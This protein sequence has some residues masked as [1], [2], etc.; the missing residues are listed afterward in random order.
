MVSRG[1]SVLMSLAVLISAGLLT[2]GGLT[3]LSPTVSIVGAVL[4]LVL[5]LL[6]FLG[7]VLSKPPAPAPS[8]GRRAPPGRPIPFRENKDN[9]EKVFTADA[10]GVTITV[11]Y[12]GKAITIEQLPLGNLAD[13][14]SGQE[15]VSEDPACPA[16]FKPHRLAIDFQAVD[17]NRNLLTRFCVPLTMR[18]YISQADVAAAGGNPD[19]LRLANVD[20]PTGWWE[21]YDARPVLDSS[22][23]RW[24]G[25]IEA[26]LTKWDD[27]PS[28]V[29]AT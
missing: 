8:G 28:G 2:L 26:K 20:H 17:A 23:P 21:V 24:V 29:G 3:E 11:P 18:I 25:Y 14:P 6:A 16:S 13:Q 27:R 5:A 15:R 4:A 19:N 12:Q 10:D 1:P 22:D 9:R 7:M